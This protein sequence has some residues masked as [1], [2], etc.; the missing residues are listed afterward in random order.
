MSLDHS[1]IRLLVCL[2]LLEGYDI[3]LFVVLMN[4]RFVLF[5]NNAKSSISAENNEIYY[6]L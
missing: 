6:R 5:L 4:N 3:Y 1:S 2:S